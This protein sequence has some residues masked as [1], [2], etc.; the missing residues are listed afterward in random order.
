MRQSRLCITQAYRVQISPAG[1]T[2]RIREHCVCKEQACSRAVQVG[3][4]LHRPVRLHQVCGLRRA[5]QTFCYSTLRQTFIAATK[6]AFERIKHICLFMA[7]PY[8][9]KCFSGLRHPQLQCV[10]IY[11]QLLVVKLPI[12]I[13]IHFV[14]QL[15]QVCLVPLLCGLRTANAQVEGCKRLA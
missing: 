1:L 5:I 10:L 14:K 12:A 4:D 13:H 7:E 3:A 15:S 8:A 6:E 11:L 2:L 9:A